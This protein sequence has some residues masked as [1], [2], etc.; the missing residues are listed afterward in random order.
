M[1]LRAALREYVQSD[2]AIAKLVGVKVRPGKAAQGDEYPFVICRMVTNDQDYV[3]EESSNLRRAL[4]RFTVWSESY[5]ECD[6]IRKL[7]R[8]RLRDLGCPQTVTIGTDG[9]QVEC[10]E[11]RADYD[12]TV[13]PNADG[14]DEAAYAMSIEFAVDHIE[15]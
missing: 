12:E 2:P 8:N 7:I 1:S 10:T 4:M 3:I 13:A 6:Q 14:S 9:V 15:P 5:E 11:L